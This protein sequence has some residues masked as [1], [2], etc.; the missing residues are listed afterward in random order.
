MLLEQYLWG[1]PQEV[2]LYIY[3]KEVKSLEKATSLAE[4]YRIICASR[5]RGA[6]R[7]ATVHVK[8][9]RPNGHVSRTIRGV[10]QGE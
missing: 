7:T 3:E 9:P 1:V 10:E 6:E 8:S 2:R 4:D 5:K